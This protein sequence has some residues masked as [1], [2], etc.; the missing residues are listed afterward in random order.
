MTVNQ[1]N[2]SH[3]IAYM[4]ALLVFAVALTTVLVLAA[5]RTSGTENGTPT[6]QKGRCSRN[7]DS[8]EVR[9]WPFVPIRPHQAMGGAD[10]AI[11][12]SLCSLLLSWRP[13][14]LLISTRSRLERNPD[15]AKCLE[16]H[17]EKAKG[18][19][20]HTAI[21]TGCTSCHEIRVNKDVTRVKLITTTPAALCFSCHADKSPAE[22]KGTI[23]QPAVRDCLKCHDPHASDNKYQL[24]K[25]TSSDP[26]RISVSPVTPRD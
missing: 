12:R 1:K 22:I 17:A 13:Q 7:P 14:S 20:V 15:S 8:C 9:C 10:R 25:P 11:W 24:L 26:K 4:V 3:R 21:S 2:R 16:C 19:N 6:S 18:K 5:E 23:H